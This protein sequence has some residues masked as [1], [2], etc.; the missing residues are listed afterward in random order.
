VAC[1]VN[2][3]HDH[4]P[5]GERDADSPERLVVASVGDDRAA[6]GEDER[7]GREPLGARAPTQAWGVSWRM[8]VRAVAAVA[9]GGSLAAVVVMTL[10]W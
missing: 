2:H 4:Q 1:G 10:E 7:E 3:G 9:L 6:A 8:E 5:E